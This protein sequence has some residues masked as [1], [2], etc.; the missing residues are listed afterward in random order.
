M[1]KYA[2]MEA[3]LESDAIGTQTLRN[4][5]TLVIDIDF[6]GILGEQIYFTLS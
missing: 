4:I 2:L 1:E 6:D 3:L 5:E